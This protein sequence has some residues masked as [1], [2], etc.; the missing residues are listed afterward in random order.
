MS[1]VP[2]PTA[3]SFL[4]ALRQAAADAS[5]L[6]LIGGLAMLTLIVVLVVLQNLFP[7]HAGGYGVGRG[8]RQLKPIDAKPQAAA[9]FP[10]KPDPAATR[11]TDIDL[12]LDKVV[13][14]KLGE[15]RLLRCRERQARI[16]LYACRGCSAWVAA[17][18]KA[19]AAP[20]DPEREG[21]ERLF[22]A[23]YGRTVTVRETTCRRRGEPAC[24]FEV[25]H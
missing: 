4:P 12:V 3:W 17:D 19:P 15:P 8:R 5:L 18:A 22:R 10:A 21:M 1:Q 2:P 16:R 11:P 23:Q 25:R 7:D 6:L 24:E 9:R 13:E 14:G 20:C